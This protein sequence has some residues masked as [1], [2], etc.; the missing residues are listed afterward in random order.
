M[1]YSRPGVFCI[2]V[3]DPGQSD[4][5]ATTLRQQSAGRPG[6]GGNNHFQRSLTPVSP[7]S[8]SS[9]QCPG[10][11]C[12]LLSLTSGGARTQTSCYEEINTTP[13]SPCLQA[14][15]PGLPS[16]T[17]RGGAAGGLPRVSTLRRVGDKCVG[18]VEANAAMLLLP[19][20]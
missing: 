13:H 12:S 11:P 17:P 15:G 20:S 8:P 19:R 7:S 3:V 6:R 16:F 9:R 5:L 18:R 10:P 4:N 2:I 1:R 14:P